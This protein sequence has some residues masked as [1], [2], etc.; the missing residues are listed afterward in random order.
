MS[1]QISQLN[2]LM[3][4]RN[5]LERQ[6]SALKEATEAISEITD[7]VKVEARE[8]NIP[9]IEIALAIAPEIANYKSKK[10]EIEPPRRTRALKQYRNPHTGEV[11][12]TRGG[13]HKILKE[14][15][16]KYGGSTVESWLEK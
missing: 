16:A 6:I 5:A 9:L 12:A 10:S 2:D 7:R 14:W 4:Q 1:G 8:R 15:K 11:I 13:N 3:E